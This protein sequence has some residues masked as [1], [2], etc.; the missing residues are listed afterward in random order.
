MDIFRP[1]AHKKGLVNHQQSTDLCGRADP[2]Y[3]IVGGKLLQPGTEVEKD[4]Y[5]GPPLA[6]S[7]SAQSDINNS[8]MGSWNVKMVRVSEEIYCEFSS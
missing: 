5:H 7:L 4:E 3:Y 1:N 6:L 2:G 8:E